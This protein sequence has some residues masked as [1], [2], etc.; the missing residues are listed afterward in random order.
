MRPK[1]KKV[2]IGYVSEQVTPV[3]G[4]QSCRDLSKRQ[5]IRYPRVCRSVL[6]SFP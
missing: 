3:P 6:L 2:F 1:R 5:R 4:A